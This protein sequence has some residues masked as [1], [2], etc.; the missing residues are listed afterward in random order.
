MMLKLMGGLLIICCG[1]AAGMFLSKKNKDKTVFLQQYISFL[2]QAKAMIEFSGAD[3][4]EIMSGVHNVPMFT[5]LID[6][7]TDRMKSGEDITSAWKSSLKE[8]AQRNE[9]D[10]ED[11]PLYSDFCEGFGELGADE[12]SAK[13]QLQIT[14]ASA[15]LEQLQKDGIIKQRLYRTVGTF[16]GVLAAVVLI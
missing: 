9:I 6:D 11:I 8:A 4:M 15:R 13:L 16:C 14:A 7:V 5:Y 3:I 10:K 2:T 12:E 1:T